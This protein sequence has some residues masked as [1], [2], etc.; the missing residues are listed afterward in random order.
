MLKLIVSATLL[1]VQTTWLLSQDANVVYNFID[2]Y[3]EIAIS[4]MHRTGIPASIK[5]AQGILESSAGRSDLAVNSNNY[6]G[7]KCGV[8]WDGGTYYKKDDDYDRRGR[9]IP[10]C[11]RAFETPEASFIEHSEFIRHPR[12]AYRYGFLFSLDRYDYKSWAWGLKQSGYATNPKYAVLLIKLIEKYELYSYDYWAPEQLLAQVNVPK[13]EPKATYNHAPIEQRTHQTF[14][15]KRHTA[16]APIIEGVVT[17]NGVKMVYAQEGETPEIIA[18]RLDISARDI[19]EYNERIDATTTALDHAERVYLG[20]KKK[21]YKGS[22]KYHEVE[23]G[24]TMYDIAQIYGIRLEKL[25]IRNRLYPGSEPAIGEKIRL[26]GMVRSKD[27]PKIRAKAPEKSYRQQE[28]DL[29]KPVPRIKRV[30]TSDKR[31]SHVVKKGD[32]LYSIANQYNL[33]VELLKENNQLASNTIR[34]GQVL[35]VD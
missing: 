23:E 4:E 32:T 16:T 35:Y 24:E 25:Y 8:D 26:R 5:L 21:K 33:T 12:K 1:L 20:K 10:S 15:W 7:L 2:R 31:S 18:A 19:M 29:E 28:P 22:R 30:V 9:L 13:E 6:F 11:F 3:K 17:N 34:P 27:R 14:G